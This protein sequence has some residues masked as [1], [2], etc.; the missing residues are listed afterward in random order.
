MK[1]KSAK[2]CRLKF[3]KFALGALVFAL[4]IWV[5]LA[6][7]QKFQG[8]R[9]RHARQGILSAAQPEVLRARYVAT[10]AVYPKDP[11]GEGVSTLAHSL[12]GRGWLQGAKTEETALAWSK[13]IKKGAFF[14]N[15]WVWITDS[16]AKVLKSIWFEPDLKAAGQ[17]Q[18]SEDGTQLR[19]RAD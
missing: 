19:L 9:P 16:D 5:A 10:D 18:F 6:G 1:R 3:A 15:G 17:L 4:L 14:R 7:G 8:V 12:H 11:S 2:E 13:E